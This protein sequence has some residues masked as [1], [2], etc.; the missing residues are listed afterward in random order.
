M[1]AD[2]IERRVLG[3]IQCVDAVTGET[4]DNQ[5]SITAAGVQFTRNRS[6]KYAIASAPG[7]L[8][9]HDS[10]FAQ[11]PTTPGLETVAI[12]VQVIDP[13]GHYL[14]RQQTIQLPRDPNPEAADGAS[15]LF[16]PIAMRLLCS[17]TAKTGSEWAVIRATVK[18]Q[19]TN[20][21]LPW[22]LI[23]VVQSNPAQVTLSQADWRGEALIA[24][25]GIPLRM[26]GSG[27]DAVSTDEVA[28]EMEVIFDP[29]LQP[30]AATADV[31]TQVDRNPTYIPD[32][33]DLETRRANLP[34][35]RLSYKV[36]SGRDRSAI[37]AVPL[38]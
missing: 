37:L 20:E 34:S 10:A 4:I 28:V 32:P 22:A 14:P 23:R 11:P 13:S 33:D 27:T 38:P 12:Q 24:V 36:A 29:K 15:S 3:V 2:L 19:T 8:Q 7:D 17:P 9:T 5:L 1:R 16:Q 25:P 18:N 30:I 31:A 6:G 26:S 35:G 21:R